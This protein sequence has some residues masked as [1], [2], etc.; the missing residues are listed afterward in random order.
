M[1]RLFHTASHRH[2]TST[3]FIVLRMPG[4]NQAVLST[5]RPTS[6]ERSCANSPASEGRIASGDGRPQRHE[7]GAASTASGKRRERG[8]RRPAPAV[9]VRCART[10]WQARITREGPATTADLGVIRGASSSW[11]VDIPGEYACG[12]RPRVCASSAGHLRGLASVLH[13]SPG[14]TRR[15]YACRGFGNPSRDD[16]VRWWFRRI[17]I[18]HSGAS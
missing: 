12:A 14:P 16:E 8:G 13:E 4:R 6:S 3:N 17:V 10:G 2:R 18:A 9:R 15:P 7:H 1:S 5:P 11:G